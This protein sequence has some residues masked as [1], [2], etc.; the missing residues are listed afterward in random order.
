MNERI[1][2]APVQPRGIRLQQLLNQLVFLYFA[3]VVFHLSIRWIDLVAVLAVAF[4][5][6]HAMIWLR[7]RRAG[8]PWYF[9][10]SA[11]SSGFNVVFMLGSVSTILLCGA[12]AF[13]L[14]HKHL[15][16]LTGR[17]HFLN[18]SNVGIVGAMLFFPDITWATFLDWGTDMTFA[19]TV[20]VL[21]GVLLA[22]VRLLHVAIVFLVSWMTLSWLFNPLS[23][24][25]IIVQVGSGGFLLY[26]LLMV[27]DPR[28][29]PATV[30]GR[31]VYAIL[32]AT[33]AVVIPLVVGTKDINLF[34]ALL[35]GGCFVPF[36]RRVESRATE[37]SGIIAG[38]AVA[39][40]VVAVL[41]IALS[42]VNARRNLDMS[43]IAERL[44]APLTVSVPDQAGTVIGAVNESLYPAGWSRSGIVAL[45]LEPVA[46]KRLAFQQVENG[47]SGYASALT[48][49]HLGCDLFM[50][51]AVAA[52]DMDLDG[53]TDLVLAKPAQGLRIYLWR[54]G[55]FSDGTSLFFPDGAPAHIEHVIA[56]DFDSDRRIDLLVTR[57]D[58]TSGAGGTLYLQQDNG[59]MRPVVDRIGAGLH[60][61][62][63]ISVVDLNGDRRLDFYIS[64]GAD[65]HSEQDDFLTAP[66]PDLFYLSATDGWQVYDL[67][68]Y[69]RQVAGR[70][71]LGMT[72]LFTDWNQDGA[73]DFLLGSDFLDPS[74]TYSGG[75]S[76]QVVNRGMIENNTMHSMSYFP[77]DVDNDGVFE[78]WENGI[79]HAASFDRVEHVKLHGPAHSILEREIL[80]LARNRDPGRFDCGVYMH[81]HSRNLCLDLSQR[82][83]ALAAGDDSL[84]AGVAAIET[85]RECIRKVARARGRSIPDPRQSAADIER[86]PPQLRENVL[87][88]KDLDTGRYINR[89][90]D[91]DAA[92]YTGF[93]WA[94]VPL[95]AD[96]DGFVD[97]YIG[98]GALMES[99]DSNRFLHNLGRGGA[100]G[101]W[102]SERAIELG[103]ADRRDTRGVVAIDMDNDGDQDLVANH[104]MGVP[105]VWE[106]RSG[107]DSLRVELR[108]RVANYYGIGS[109]VRM[110]TTRG[111]QVQSM[112]SGGTW[113]S[114]GPWALHF[115]IADGDMPAELLVTWP[116]G[117]TTAV[118]NPPVNHR[119]IIFQ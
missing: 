25:T 69:P 54:S 63:G 56:A 6:E 91:D 107:G 4:I 101:K 96:N 88:K 108:G 59:T 17:R 111:V 13:G 98:N 78:L 83:R 116:D 81:P 95:D 113:N 3:K 57:S 8:I 94:T 75:L 15:V 76:M 73:I 7:S 74:L 51:S 44:S 84:C 105:T 61:S 32:T 97:L 102:F 64:Y 90:R 82:R 33:F 79:S 9:S 19:L 110:K 38:A 99:H 118:A 28:S 115:G 104:F 47:L 87:L 119:I 114:S 37:P 39:V 48:A 40:Y 43:T 65:W 86:F 89:L 52:A 117:T 60:S 35:L 23:A 68:W 85:R 20:A 72:V 112:T 70:P 42:P 1:S 109:L 67:G 36:I 22:R 11:L 66:D 100:G 93:S 2:S 62:G 29:L 50:Y 10:T 103:I 58:Y 49:A 21:A 18:P 55:Q 46:R 14:V 24:G 106:N 27:T 12:V 5:V 16:Q 30:R 92:Q 31:I 41:G 45:P 80:H 77:V 26:A 53:H 71:L 34:L